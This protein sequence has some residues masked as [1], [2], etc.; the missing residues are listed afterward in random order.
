MEDDATHFSDLQFSLSEAQDSMMR[1]ICCM[2]DS[3]ELLLRQ[4]AVATDKVD[5]AKVIDKK[6]Q[7]EEIAKEEQAHRTQVPMLSP[8]H[9]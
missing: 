2:Q 1:N 3:R 8:I 4:K 5:L 9:P 6:V 7:L